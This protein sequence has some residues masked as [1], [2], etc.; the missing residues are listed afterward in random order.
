MR[1]TSHRTTAHSMDNLRRCPFGEGGLRHGMPE[2]EWECQT[3]S[4][5]S[6]TTWDKEAIHV[7]SQLSIGVSGLGWRKRVFTFGGDLARGIG[8]S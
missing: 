7:V 5:W 4:K 1:R 3:W 2:P 8:V 6:E